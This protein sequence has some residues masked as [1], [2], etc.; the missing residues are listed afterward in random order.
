MTAEQEQQKEAKRLAIDQD[1]LLIIDALESFRERDLL[2]R[3]FNRKN[4]RFRLHI[5]SAAV[6]LLRR[7]YG[8]TEENLQ[9]L[10][11]SQRTDIPQQ[12]RQQRQGQFVLPEGENKLMAYYD[13]LASEDCTDAV[14]Q[15]YGLFVLLAKF[16]DLHAWIVAQD[17]LRKRLIKRRFPPLA[18]R[19][20][21]SS[22]QLSRATPQ[23]Q[24][25]QQHKLVP[26]Q[27][28]DE[29]VMPYE[30]GT[31]SNDKPMSE[32]ERLERELE[33]EREQLPEDESLHFEVFDT[34]LFK[35]FV[36]RDLKRLDRL[37]EHDDSFI[38]LSALVMQLRADCIATC[39]VPVPHR[40]EDLKRAHR[41]LRQKIE[42]YHSHHHK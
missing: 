25:Q 39:G 13:W 36:N 14:V 32:S 33:E 18:P 12:Q 31:L 42:S 38:T 17:R 11:E 28:E 23:Q 16:S 35:A 37:A 9:K 34:E 19:A 26:P 21:I 6:S 7:K 5:L 40:G 2:Y 22:R 10:R 20:L 15:D 1:N 3:F 29:Y 27:E 4:Q 24:Q 30:T 41:E 8:Y